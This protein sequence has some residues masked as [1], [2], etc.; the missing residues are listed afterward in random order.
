MV[1]FGVG[2][3]IGGQTMGLV[4]DKFGSKVGSIKNWLNIV[5]MVAVTQVSVSILKYNVTSVLM[6]FTWGYLD[7]C[8]NIHTL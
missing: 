1:G 6:C 3:A 4:I 7:S 8:F 5:L 2:A